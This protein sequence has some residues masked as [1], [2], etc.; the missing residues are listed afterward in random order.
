MCMCPRSGLKSAASYTELKCTMPPQHQEPE[1]PAPEDQ[2]CPH[3]SWTA[4]DGCNTCTCPASGSKSEA[5]CTQMKCLTRP[6]PEGKCRPLLPYPAGDG[7]NTC[8]CPLSGLKSGAHC[9]RWRCL[10]M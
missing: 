2:C 7:L 5:G 1:E 3:L 10:T 9:T 6:P 8:M 4:P